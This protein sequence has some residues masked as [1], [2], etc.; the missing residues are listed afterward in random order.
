MW[1]PLY[2][3]VGNLQGWVAGLYIEPDRHRVRRQANSNA[4]PHL[5]ECPSPGMLDVELA[6]WL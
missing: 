5:P 4:G 3:K 1:V 6:S 2:M